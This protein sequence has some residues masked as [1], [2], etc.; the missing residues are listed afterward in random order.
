MPI[1]VLYFFFNSFMLP[2]GLLY[3]TILTPLFLIWLLKYPSLNYLYYF[4]IVTIPF[5]LIH[6]VQGVHAAYYARSYVLLFTWFV[7]GI[8]FYLV[9]VKTATPCDPYFVC[10]C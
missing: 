1:A 6:F 7:F 2:Q 4:F 3:T 10:W 5:A 8:A 9:F